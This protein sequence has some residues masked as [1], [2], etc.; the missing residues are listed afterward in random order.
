[1]RLL[2]V[3]N[4]FPPTLGG[5]ENYTYS[6]AS[7]WKPDDVAVLTRQV[8]GWQEF[9]RALPFEVIRRPARTLLPTPD[10]LGLAA[11]TVRSRSAD[12]V[13]FASPLPL[14]LLGPRLL[15]RTGIPYTVSIHGGE[16]LLPAALPVGRAL[17]RRALS[18][19]SVLLP[20][21]SFTRAAVERFFGEPP[22]LEV[23]TPGVDPERFAPG[24]PPAE[25][26]PPGGR[27][28]VSISRLVARKG[29]ATLI[30]ALP[31]VLARHPGAR[32]LVVGGGPDLGRLRRLAETH[33]VAG[34]VTFA[35]PR[36][37]S[38]VPAWYRS[39]EVFALPSRAR[40]GE[41]ETEGFP[42]VYLEAAACGLPVV[43]GD[44]G[45][46]RDAV[47]DGETGILVDGRDAEATARAVLRLLDD[48][49]AAREM[50]ARG[51]SRV[52]RTFTWDLVAERFRKALGRYTS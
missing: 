41:V 40:F 19:A 30:R 9:D 49:E 52:L 24:V 44:A 51:R 47:A 32:A 4:D 2:V 27:V 31:R 14:A 34:A 6:L 15:D 21:S 39:G 26:P 22:P 37:W 43:A 13:H 50:G 48:P 45:G 23:V 36:P 8:P 25:E 1:M 18:R 5:I 11:E 28:I 16:F 12:A 35:G 7:R 3:T 20:V 17:L 10:L 42:L 33:G 29:P 38:E 46:V